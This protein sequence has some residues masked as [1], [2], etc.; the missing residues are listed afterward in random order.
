MS[1][2]ND[3]RVLGEVL[4]EKQRFRDANSLIDEVLDLTKDRPRIVEDF[5]NLAR[6]LPPMLVN[7]GPLMTMAYLLKRGMGRDEKR[8]VARMIVMHLIGWLHSRGLIRDIIN[9]IDDA[10]AKNTNLIYSDDSWRKV[11]ENILD[12]L[13]K[14]E[15]EEL[16]WITDEL[17]RYSEALKVLTQ[18]RLD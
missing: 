14:K 15:T 11:A 12:E 9:K 17:L 10:D 18:A 13:L 2:G 5:S 8:F 6:R 16:A 4:G 7:S 1:S 3:D